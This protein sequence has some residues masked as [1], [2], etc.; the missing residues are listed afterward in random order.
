[1]FGPLAEKKLAAPNT[2]HQLRFPSSW[3]AVFED[4]GRFLTLSSSIQ[5]VFEDGFSR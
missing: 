3:K 1:V 2:N 5:A 4:G